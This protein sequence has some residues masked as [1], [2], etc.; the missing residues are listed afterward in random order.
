MPQPA[1]L[2]QK[3]PIASVRPTPAVSRRSALF[4]VPG[5]LVRPSEARDTLETQALHKVSYGMLILGTPTV[6]FDTLMFHSDP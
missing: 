1:A 2:R 5:V 3:V 6:M 4:L